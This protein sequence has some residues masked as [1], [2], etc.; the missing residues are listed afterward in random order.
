MSNRKPPPSSSAKQRAAARSAAA[1]E[2]I[3]KAQRRR[4]LLLVGG[5]VLAIAVI[6][7]VLVIVKVVTNAGGAKS[8]EKGTNAPAAI[9]SKIANVPAAVLDQVGAGQT[10]ARPLPISAPSLTQNGK[11]EILY[12]G[13]EFCPYCAGERWALA[14]AL[15]RFGDLHNLS[16]T[17]SSPT[18]QPPSLQTLSFHGASYTSDYLALTAKEL[19]SN[20]VVNGTYAPLDKLTPAE[21]ALVQKYDARPYV[22]SSGIPFVDL[23]G[24]WVLSGAT[25][26]V[27]VLQGKTREQIAAALSDPS[28][29]IAQ[30]VL[31]AANALTAAMCTLTGQQPGAVCSSPGVRAAAA[32]LGSSAGGTGGASTLSPSAG[33]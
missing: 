20:Q 13:A 32:T 1:R 8:G 7:G 31:G 18:D 29:P 28:S 19:Q 16:V 23:G 10:V 30:G 15:E 2:R 24:K 5:A 4:Q 3:R 22:P 25:Y 33:G 27:R 26:D 17:S 6:V 14:V 9:T 12:A 21:Q 11:P